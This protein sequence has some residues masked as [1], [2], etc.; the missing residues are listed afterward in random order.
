MEKYEKIHQRLE[1]Q[2][3]SADSTADKPSLKT[4][5]KDNLERMKDILTLKKR[6]EDDLKALK[7]KVEEEI[8][9]INSVKT[10][11][12]MINKVFITFGTK[13][14]AKKCV[15]KFRNGLLSKF[16]IWMSTKLCLTP[17]IRYMNF[18]K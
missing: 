5:A 3:S 12:M 9:K 16:L 6:S 7:E 2:K 13:A 17:D 8:E 14:E 10:K 1:R 18:K 11:D 4:K 15:S